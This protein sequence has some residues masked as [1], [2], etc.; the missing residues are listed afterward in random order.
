MADY[1]PL[2]A[3]AVAALPNSTRETR[4]AI[5]ERAR[6]ALLGQLQSLNPPVSA[7]HLAAESKALDDAI[8]RLEAELAREPTGA[9]APPP[10]AAAPPKPAQPAPPP[11]SAKPPPPPARPAP[12]VS[13]GAAPAPE[14]PP[15]AAP[16]L[17]VPERRAEPPPPD[18]RDIHLRAPQRP[19]DVPDFD[20]PLRGRA[21]DERE[22][23]PPVAA[24]PPGGANR[25]DAARPVAP[26]RPETGR[27][28]SRQVLIWIPLI[29]L[30]GGGIGF[31]AWR[32]RVPQE[33]FTRPRASAV[34]TRQPE[35]SAKIND[36]AGGSPGGA[37]SSQTAPVQQAQQRPQQPAPRPAQPSQPAQQ[38]TAQPAPQQAAPAAE[39]TAP[40][41]QRAA[42]LVQAAVND[43]QN[44]ETHVGAVV[45]RLEESKRPGANGSPA[46][47]ADVDIAAVGLR[48]VFLIEK[49]NDP[50]LR[51][52][53][54]LTFR[55]L[56]QETSTLPGIAE[57]GSPQMRNETAPAVE[58]LAGAQAKIT[59]NIYIVALNADPAFTA[60]N[61]DTLRSRGWFDFPIRLMDGR[62]AKI[63]IE[64]GAPGERLLNQAIEQWQR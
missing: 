51:A 1:Y 44:V 41:A 40:V 10:A 31:A 64:K 3:R 36:R 58:P 14:R 27:V 18:A 38:T 52:S 42:I 9:P 43:P 11:P 28:V 33:E 15:S 17:N 45:W 48:L 49:N 12:P 59:D 8:S 29:L 24:R 37:D 46:L 35:G 50:T 61:L 13:G 5:Y 26:T 16:A 21:A 6:K 56:P 39:Q 30:I 57:M 2:L 34:E 63:T 53:H 60:R 25:A 23:P 55:F 62:I 20:A 19:A 4:T 7:E 47:R 32:L 22:T 54:M